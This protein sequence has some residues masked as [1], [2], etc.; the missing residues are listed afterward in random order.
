MQQRFRHLTLFTVAFV[1]TCGALLVFM[2]HLGLFE[3]SSIPI[4]VVS[5]GAETRLDRSSITE[6]IATQESHETTRLSFD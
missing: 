4:E 1:L 5:G 3:V 2:N 6:T